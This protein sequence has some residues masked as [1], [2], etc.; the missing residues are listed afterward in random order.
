M[1]SD[2]VGKNHANWFSHAS[3]ALRFVF[4]STALFIAYHYY[5]PASSSHLMPSLFSLHVAGMSLGVLF[6]L[7]ESILA[8]MQMRRGLIGEKRDAAALLHVILTTAGLI[9]VLGGF[10]AIYTNK[11]EMNKKHF[12]STH[13]Q[14]GLAFLILSLGASA[15]GLMSWRSLAHI[16]STILP[17]FIKGKIKMIHRWSGTLTWFLGLV[18]IEII[19]FKPSMYEPFVSELVRAGVALTGIIMMALSANASQA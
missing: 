13:S 2:A 11:N 4:V 16:S 15:G 6:F 18:T 17:S 3:V 8:S 7:P 9:F 19:L 10:L 12:T 5:S 14:F 1:A